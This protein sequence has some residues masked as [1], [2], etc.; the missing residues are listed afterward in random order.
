MYEKTKMSGLEDV[1]RLPVGEKNVA[2]AFELLLNEGVDI[3]VAHV[4]EFGYRKI[5]FDIATGDVW[6]K[7]KPLVKFGDQSSLTGRV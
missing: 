6:A 2:A 7:F 3:L 4:G 5:V 1:E